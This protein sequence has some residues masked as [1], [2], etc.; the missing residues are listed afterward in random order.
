MR[1]VPSDRVWID[2]AAP[3]PL[4]AF[5]IPVASEPDARDATSRRKDICEELSRGT[6]TSSLQGERFMNTVWNLLVPGHRSAIGLATAVTL[7]QLV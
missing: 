1:L 4:P 6:D 3:G 5:P 7:G 2:A